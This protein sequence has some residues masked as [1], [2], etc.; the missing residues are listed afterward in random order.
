M[1]VVASVVI[2]T[3]NRL[4]SLKK[5]VR[6]LEAQT[7]SGKH[8][9]VVLVADGCT[10]GTAEAMKNYRGNLNLATYELPGLGAASARNKGASV[11]NGRIL[12]FLDDDMEPHPDFVHQ[13]IAAHTSA[14]RAVIGYS[15]LKLESAAG[16]QRKLL[17]TWWEE[18][19][20]EL[21]RS[22][23]RFRYEDLTSGNFSIDANLF[24]NVDGFD[25]TLLCREDYELGFRLI[26]AGAEFYFAAKALAFH[27]DEVTDLNRSLQRKKTEGMA[28][29]QIRRKHVNFRNKEEAFYWSMGKL[30][31][32]FLLNFTRD[33]PK[34][35]DSL[36]YACAYTIRY[37]EK[38]NMRNAWLKV[39]YHLHQYWY[40]RGVLKECKTIKEL[41]QV[42]NTSISRPEKICELK[43]NLHEELTNIERQL[44]H[45][46]PEALH[47][48]FA[49]HYIGH[50][51]YDPGSEPIKGI[52]LRRILKDNFTEELY[53]IL[54]RHI[55]ILKEKHRK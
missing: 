10:D 30:S 13:H 28:D 42:L 31:R 7:Y 32:T 25:N 46:R 43:I 40:L 50:V 44:D 49:Q 21:K 34:L 26:H 35:S 24:K 16:I 9:E 53:K 5:M 45:S 15:P 37:F 3:H 36:A 48:Y 51:N 20:R 52:H 1:S 11:A 27:C 4:N 6:L 14:N 41:K 12:I 54:P 33:L 17:R 38:L 22:D 8:F 18:K 39:N 55:S 2:P 23:H 47:I 29:V 19:F